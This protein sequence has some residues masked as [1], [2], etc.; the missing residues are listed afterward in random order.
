M[1][2]C[3]TCKEEFV[4]EGQFCKPEC[5]PGFGKGSK[6]PGTPRF[7]GRTAARR[8]RRRARR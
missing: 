5:H 2:Q 1:A 4:G 6:H 7:P 8:R 3:D